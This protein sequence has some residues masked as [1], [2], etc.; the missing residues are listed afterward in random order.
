MPLKTLLRVD[1]N[2]LICLHV[3]LEEQSVTRTASRLHL[4]Q[5]AVSKN[6]AKLRE[7]FDDPLFSRTSHGLQPTFRARHMQGALQGILGDIDKL[8]QPPQFDPKLSSRHYKMALVESIYPLALPH[9]IS[10][11]FSLGPQLTL[12]TEQWGKQSFQK[13]LNGEVDF[14]ITGKDI[15]P[16]DAKLT[17]L[18]PQGIASHELYRDHQCCLVRP[19]HPALKKHWDLEAY[20]DQRHVQARCGVDGNDRWLL[21]F[22]LAEQDKYRDIAI[23]VADFNSAA[24]IAT[25]TDLVFTSPSHFGALIAKQLNLVILPLPYP[26]PPMAYTLFWGQDQ[27]SDPAHCW[28]R[29]LIIER[30]KHL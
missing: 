5:S 9:F 2:L 20:L 13:I 14:G 16:S 8:T 18:P 23:C 17:M 25:H 1:L 21:D 6:L 27:E 3:L 29:S 4:S 30:C 15:H 26:L 11:M 28:L 24:S 19:D 10:D 22:K 12:D 7:W